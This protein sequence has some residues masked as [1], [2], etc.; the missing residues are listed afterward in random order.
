MIPPMAQPDA[1]FLE[2]ARR[3]KPGLP[4]P[5]IAVG[6]LGDPKVAQAAVA[7]GACDFV[8]L[9]RP[10]LAD[11]DWVRKVKTG[12]PVRRCIACNTCISTMRSGAPLYCLVN[13]ETGREEEYADKS[14][15]KGR[16]IA[17]VGA[18]PAGLTYASL[19]GAHNR[20]TVFERGPS[21]G[22]ALRLAG[23][24]PRFQEVAAENGSLAR[25]V[26]GLEA[27]Y[28]HAGVGMR[29]GVDVVTHP[30]V[31]TGFDLVVVATGAEYPL[32]LGALVRALFTSGMARWPRSALVVAATKAARFSRPPGPTPHGPSGCRACPIQRRRRGDRRCGPTRQIS[33]RNRLCLRGC[34]ARPAGLGSLRGHRRH[35]SAW[36]RPPAVE[37]FV[38]RD[39]CCERTQA[40][41]L[42]LAWRG[43]AMAAPGGRSLP[44]GLRF[45]P[46]ANLFW[47]RQQAL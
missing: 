27:A 43:G 35:G 5:V 38:W 44:A 13:A 14:P 36:S 26:A 12:V 47:A 25:Y 23:L 31:L 24:A 41:W 2:F 37:L 17:V 39:C 9:G 34:L 42:Q 19:V 1:A 8:A 18:G 20:V 46:S 21:P 32:G 33:G 22:G 6:R 45:R 15:P 11:A 40:L 29:Y 3:L 30:E 7:E 4:V 10:L 28:L 16:R